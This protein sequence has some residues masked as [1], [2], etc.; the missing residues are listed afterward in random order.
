MP[1]VGCEK[2]CTCTLEKCCASCKC[3]K[4]GTCGCNPANAPAAGGCCK[5][6][7]DSAAHAQGKCCGN[8]DKK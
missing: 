6:K 5:K 7:D 4:P 3:Q 8:G 2:N 1:C